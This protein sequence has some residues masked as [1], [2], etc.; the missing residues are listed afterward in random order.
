M[1]IHAAARRGDLAELRW[2]FARG[3]AADARDGAGNTPLLATLESLRAFDRRSKPHATP[4]TVQALL[5]AGADPNAVGERGLTPIHL[6]VQ[7]GEVALVERL[8]RAGADVQHRTAGG[9]TTLLHACYQPPG[10]GKLAILQKLISA[11]IDANAA[12]DYGESP[13]SVCLYFGDFA[14][15]RLLVK[16]GSEPARLGWSEPMARFALAGDQEPAAWEAVR[17]IPEQSK[18]AWR[19]TPL[20]LATKQGSLAKLDWLLAQGADVHASAHCGQTA[21]H[22]AAEHDHLKVVDRLLELGLA[23]DTRNEFEETS[24][25]H[26]CEWDAPRVVARLLG[27]GAS[28]EAEDHVQSRAIHR[29]SSLPVW[30]LLVER[31]GADL[32]V[33]SGDGRWPL[34]V[35][36]ERND[37]EA[38]RWLV[39]AGAKV[40]LTGTGATA[41]HAAIQSDAREVAAFLLG[42][43]ADPNAPDVDG[44]TPLFCA[45][46]RQAIALLLAQGA[47]PTVRDQAGGWAVDRMQDPVLREALTGG[48]P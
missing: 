39:A 42:Q 31:G 45:R 17:A 18:T 8:E 5:D 4:E 9:Y 12:S 35:A 16:A 15:L 44:W 36:A 37:L 19:L 20:L 40:A 34:Q 33:V 7:T 10:K 3:A 1:Q 43:G 32:N 48:R 38:A 23:T 21:L 46:S 28:V 27:A 22:L 29:A 24:L 6:A 13:L 47:D 26:A 25:M 14:A 11:G 2:C 41:L 30:R